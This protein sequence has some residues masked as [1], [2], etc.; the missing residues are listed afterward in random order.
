MEAVHWTSDYIQNQAALAMAN[1][2]MG[3]MCC[4]SCVFSKLWNFARFGIGKEALNK[5]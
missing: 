2:E 5:E 3:K 1:P 4:D